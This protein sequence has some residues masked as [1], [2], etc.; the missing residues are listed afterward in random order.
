M[1]VTG[2]DDGAVGRVLR[3]RVQQTIARGGVAAPLIHRVA[4]ARPAERIEGRHHHLIGEHLPA[5]ARAREPVVQPAFLLGAKHRALGIGPVAAR[6]FFVSVAARVV[7]AVLSSIEEKDSR[8]RSPVERASDREVCPGFRARHANGLMLPPRL[9]RRGSPRSHLLLGHHRILAEQ[10]GVVV[11]HLVI[12]PDDEPWAQAMSRA[13]QRIHLVL[14]VAQTIAGEI[15]RFGGRMLARRDRRSVRLV[16]V[17]AE[18]RDEIEILARKMRVRC[19]ESLLV[20]LTGHEREVKRSRRVRVRRG[21]ESPDLARRVAGGEAV[22]VPAIRRESVEVDV[23]A[24][25][26]LRRGDRGALFGELRE[27]VVR[28]ELPVDDLTRSGHPAVRLERTR[29]KTRPQDAAGR[30]W[31]T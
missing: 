13:K 3:D 27:F 12:V 4:D 24:V 21:A 19:V 31:I 26:E 7:A 16:D 20:V 1:N 18:V 14:A 11:V 22:V 9:I 10:A 23:H 8:K 29:R 17:V 15:E 25:A 5:G 2:D 28:G 6:D 30:C